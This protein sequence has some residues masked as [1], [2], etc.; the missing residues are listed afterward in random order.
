METTHRFNTATERQGSDD[1]LWRDAL[2]E[3]LER[4]AGF[5]EDTTEALDDIDERLSRVEDAIATLANTAQA[6]LERLEADSIR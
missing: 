4:H 2:T 5:A 1:L 6:I 3:A